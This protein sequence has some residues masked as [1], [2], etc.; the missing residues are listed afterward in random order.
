LK[1]YQDKIIFKK[2]E[3]NPITSFLRDFSAP[4]KL[5]YAFTEEKYEFLVKHD[6][7]EFN[8]FE[9]FQDYAKEIILNNYNCKNI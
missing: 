5:N 4:I 2:I 3:N 7:N 1:D 6:T 8:R 9:A